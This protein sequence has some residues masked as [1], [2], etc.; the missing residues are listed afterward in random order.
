[1]VAPAIPFPNTFVQV[2]PSLVDL[3][4]PVVVAAN[5]PGVPNPQGP[6][7]LS[8]YIISSTKRNA[9][10]SV[11]E[12]RCVQ[13]APASKL[14]HIPFPRIASIFNQPSPV[15]KNIF[16]LLLKP[17]PCVMQVIARLFKVSLTLFHTVV[18]ALI[19]LVYHNPPPTPPA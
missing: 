18:A 13:V 3:Y 1:M 2:S 5:T 6:P 8:T 19:S 15:P 7:E 16:V 12:R 17:F 9:G 14:R 4:T 10:L 11:V